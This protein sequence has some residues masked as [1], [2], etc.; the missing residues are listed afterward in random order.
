L[1]LL[2]EAAAT[3]GTLAAAGKAA[4]ATIGAGRIVRATD[5]AAAAKKAAKVAIKKKKIPTIGGRRPRG[6]EWGYAG[7]P[8][9]SG[10]WFTEQGFPD[11]GPYVKAS[12]KFEN[13]KGNYTTDID[14]ANKESGFSRTPDGYTWHHVEDGKTMQLVPL[15]LHRQVPHT[16]GV[17]VIRNGGFDP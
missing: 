10:V 1:R 2:I 9:P 17:A 6:W 3:K 14:M 5:D 15:E 11:F 8:H 13:L 16:G 12:H 7:K 4:S